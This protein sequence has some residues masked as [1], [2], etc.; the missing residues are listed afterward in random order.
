MLWAVYCTTFF[1]FFR[2]GELLQSSQAQ[3]IPIFHISWGDMAVDNARDPKML[4]CHLRQ[5]KTDQCGRGVDIVIGSTGCELCPVATVLSYLAARGSQQGPF[6]LKSTNCP[7]L[8][9]E[10][11][12]EIRGLLRTLGLPIDHY[13]WH[14]FHIGAATSA[15]WRTQP[16]NSWVDGSAPPFF[17]TSGRPTRDLQQ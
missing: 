16:F 4:K 13:A 14:S 12:A 15:A 9:Q 6:L 5:S 2:L 11:I 7:L 3:F 17:A 10:F 1:G 8:K